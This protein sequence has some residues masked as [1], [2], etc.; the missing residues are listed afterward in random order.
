MSERFQDRNDT[1]VKYDKKQIRT[2]NPLFV[3]WWK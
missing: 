1:E 3:A 2:E